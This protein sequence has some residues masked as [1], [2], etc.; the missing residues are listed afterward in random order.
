M[1][2]IL[3]SKNNL[4]IRKNNDK[5]IKYAKIIFKEYYKLFKKE[6]INSIKNNKQVNLDVYKED[7]ESVLKL[8][9]TKIINNKN[10]S[11]F[12]SQLKTKKEDKVDFEPIE[13]LAT[14]EILKNVDII[15]KERTD[16][17]FSNL[18]KKI[19]TIYTNSQNKFQNEIQYLFQD[20]QE[21]RNKINNL[22]FLFTQN[23]KIEKNK[24]EKDIVKIQEKIQDKQNTQ[25]LIILTNFS[26]QYDKDII[27]EKSTIHSQNE[28]DNFD[29]IKR[30]KEIESFDLSTAIVINRIERF[31]KDK[32][33]IAEWQNPLD[34]KSRKTHAEAHGQK[35]KIGELF[36]IKNEITGEI[37]KTDK[38]RGDGLSPANSINCRCTLLYS[39]QI[40][41][42]DDRQTTQNLP[43]QNLLNFLR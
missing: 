12:T 3:Q 2:I 18:I 6:I 32:T 8:I 21:K 22:S 24:L 7:F 10:N 40:E 13:L 17:I 23:A 33:I 11:I 25:D 5:I 19:E 20:I 35:R 9:F 29:E 41:L 37:E 27:E 38:P 39:I 15:A 30:Q 31:I 36:E 42:T 28:V 43:Y 34:E 26:R 4:E 14:Q 1:K 16:L